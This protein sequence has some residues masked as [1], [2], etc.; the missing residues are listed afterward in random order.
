MC[1][2]YRAL[3]VPADGLRVDAGVVVAQLA[4]GRRD[5]HAGEVADGD[6]A[7]LLRGPRRGDGLARRAQELSSAAGKPRL[8]GETAVLPA[9]VDQ[10]H[11]EVELEAVDPAVQ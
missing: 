5:D 1:E 2:K 8:P 11:N 10:S 3:S 7:R 4:R 9:G 6:A